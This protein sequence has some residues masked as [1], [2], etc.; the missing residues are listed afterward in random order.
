MRDAIIVILGVAS[1]CVLAFLG[2]I[3]SLF[4][5]TS[6]SRE[7]ERL[8]AGENGVE[9]KS[10]KIVGQGLK[11]EFDDSPAMKYVTDS[12]R[13]ASKE[14]FVPTHQHGHTF[15]AHVVLSNGESVRVG[16]WTPDDTDGFTISYPSDSLAD[17]TYYWIPLARPAPKLVSDA[18]GQMRNAH[19]E[20]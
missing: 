15:G 11:I 20:K 17:P 19:K 9:I 8:L 3:A 2:V 6:T 10:L 1:L 16:C 18:L 4:F 7:F 5:G 13:R 14:G 12:F